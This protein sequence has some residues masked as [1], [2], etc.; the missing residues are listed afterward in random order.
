VRAGTYGRGATTSTPPVAECGALCVV[1]DP[2]GL[3]A[4]R[5][6]VSDDALDLRLH[7]RGELLA[8]L[9]IH[10]DVLDLGPPGAGESQFRPNP[11]PYS[12]SGSQ[13]R[14]FAEVLRRSRL[15]A[16]AAP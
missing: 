13:R 2:T 14:P 10:G 16:G 3:R 5:G 6:A 4:V 12:W 7:V 15:R 9:S 11:R 8:C 1:F